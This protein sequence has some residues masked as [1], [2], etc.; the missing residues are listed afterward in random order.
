MTFMLL[1]P[2]LFLNKKVNAEYEK[3]N[4]ADVN[5][6]LH[7]IVDDWETIEA[8]P[9]EVKYNKYNFDY[10]VID[11]DGRVVLRTKADMPEDI[12]RATTERCTIRDIEIEGEEVG[13]LLIDNDISKYREQIYMQYGKAYIVCAV[14]EAVI[15]IIFL[16]WVYIAVIKPF[17]KLRQ[18]ATN[19]SSGKLDIPLDMD[20]ANMF[21]AFTESF[22]IMREELQTARQKEYEAQ[23]SKVELIA[24]LSHDIKTPVASI[25][26]MSELLAA[27]SQD[28]K[29]TAKLN[30]IVN[31]TNQIDVMVNDL[32]AST[33]NDL[34]KLD[35]TPTEQHSTIIEKIIRDADYQEYIDELN[36]DEC[37]ILCDPI[38]TSQ[39]INNIIANS[40]KYADTSI[41]VRS[42]VDSEYLMISF[43]DRGGGVSEDD[44]PVI[45]K[46]FRRG[47]NSEGKQGAG[48]GLAIASELME[49][50]GGV[51]ECCNA[52]GGFRVTLMFKM[53]GS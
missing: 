13:K 40:Y 8:D 11:S 33:L 17:E 19:I 6:L 28:E 41:T 53:A 48:L 36:I 35:A 49:K 5:Q 37:L 2:I 32:F 50:M 39:V 12:G 24:Q 14:F 16:I 23:R 10:A 26:A 47:K 3:L 21:G 29:Q 15:I 31:K 22:D 43:T 25:K 45:T 38:R 44:L 51:L 9:S 27:M 18:F 1:I 46:R 4:G 52:D 30:S 34:E 20:R 42:Q 7:E